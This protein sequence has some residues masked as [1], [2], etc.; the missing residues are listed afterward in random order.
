VI[1][2][3]PVTIVA[4]TLLCLAGCGQTGALYLPDEGIGT[5]VAIRPIDASSGAAPGSEAPITT[6]ITAPTTAPTTADPAA[7]ATAPAAD[8]KKNQAPTAETPPA[9]AP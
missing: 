5:P 2:R 1:V 4:A 7:A 8:K 3:I 9:P 6:P